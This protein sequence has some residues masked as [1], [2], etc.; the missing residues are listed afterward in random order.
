MKSPAFS[1]FV[2]D[3]LCSKTVSKLHSKTRS[4]VGAYIYLL[5]NSWLEDPGCTLPND[6]ET[7]AGYARVSLEEWKE[8]KPI[9]LEKFEVN[10]EGRLFNA[11]LMEEWEKQQARKSAGSLGGLAKSVA[12]PLAKRCLSYSSSFSSSSSVPNTPTK[13]V[14][15]KKMKSKPLNRPQIELIQR[16]EACLDGKWTND[17]GKWIDRV[18]E[19]FGL[20][21]RVIAEVENAATEKRINTSAAQY[22]EYTWKDFG[23]K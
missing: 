9:I 23:G 14:K 21:E 13:L 10:S 8:L 6:D 7:L 18:K 4:G 22:A 17:A 20:C 1:F 11:R 3:W 16:F 12:N 5:A 15:R 2:R 19:H